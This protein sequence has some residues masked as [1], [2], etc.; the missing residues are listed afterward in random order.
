[1]SLYEDNLNS[2]PKKAAGGAVAAASGGGGYT[3]ADV[4]KHNLDALASCA[5]E[6]TRVGVYVCGF[7]F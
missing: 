5:Q 6:C 1:M 2:A 4:A 7:T 3:L